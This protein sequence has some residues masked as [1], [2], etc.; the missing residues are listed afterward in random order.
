MQPWKLAEKK[1]KYQQLPALPMR[2]SNSLLSSE[3]FDSI[4]SIYAAIDGNEYCEFIT[5]IYARLN[6]VR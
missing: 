3:K 5:I 2:K 6:R 1:K 4:V